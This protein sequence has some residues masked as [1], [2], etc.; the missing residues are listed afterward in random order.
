MYSLR[1]NLRL[2]NLGADFAIGIHLDQDDILAFG[3]ILLQLRSWDGFAQPSPACGAGG[4]KLGIVQFL[5]AP[6]D[7]KY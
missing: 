5:S 6:S 1:S 3:A 2:D 7:R 4:V